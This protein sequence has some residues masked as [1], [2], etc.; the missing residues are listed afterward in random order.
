MLTFADLQNIDQTLS[1]RTQ[2]QRAEESK[3]YDGIEVEIIGIVSEIYSHAVDIWIGDELRYDGEYSTPEV[4][5]ISNQ[6]ISMSYDKKI[7]NKMHTFNLRDGIRVICIIRDYFNKWKNDDGYEIVSIE[8]INT[9]I[10][11]KNKADEIQRVEN[12]RVEFLKNKEGFIEFAPVG[13]GFAALIGAIVLGIAGCKSCVDHSQILGQSL[14]LLTG[15]LVGGV[16]GALIG[17]IIA[18]IGYQKFRE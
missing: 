11:R 10:E 1:S 2:I 16:I 14:N 18:F 15:T 3:K 8:K 5:P 7:A 6:K 17:I 4:G 13:V 12:E 9:A